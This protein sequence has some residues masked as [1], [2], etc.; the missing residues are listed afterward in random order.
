[1]NEKSAFRFTDEDGKVCE[2]IVGFST[3]ELQLLRQYQGHVN[4]IRE[5]RFYKEGRGVHLNVTWA[6]ARG[7]VTTVSTPP[8]DDVQFLLYKLRPIIL[9]DEPASFNRTKSLLGRRFKNSPLTPLLK[10]LGDQYTG[11]RMQ[12]MVKMRS[13]GVLMNCEEMLFTWLNAHEYHRDAEKQ[14][15]LETLHKVLPLKWSQGVFVCLVIEKV[16]AADNL[17]Q[18]CDL[19]LGKCDTFEFRI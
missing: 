9:H 8:W 17:S 4:D 19:M 12:A 16:K 2:F 1:M 13:N 14:V 15:L 7:L 5:T 6:E 11:Q 10:F 18:L 3:D